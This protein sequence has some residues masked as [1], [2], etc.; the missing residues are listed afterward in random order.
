MS[1]Q[2]AAPDSKGQKTHIKFYTLQDI[3][4]GRILLLVP[5]QAFIF[6]SIMH[7]RCIQYFL[8]KECFSLPLGLFN[9][10]RFS[11]VF[12]FLLQPLFWEKYLQQIRTFIYY[13]IYFTHRHRYT[14]VCEFLLNELY[15][16]FSI[17]KLSYATYKPFDNIRITFAVR[18]GKILAVKDSL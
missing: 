16:H 3:S 18:K 13:F 15:I 14:Q 17:I 11:H 4:I 9:C 12:Y 2:L 7:S 8:F 10:I 6:L 1:H 5:E